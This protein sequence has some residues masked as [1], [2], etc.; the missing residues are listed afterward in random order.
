MV[1]GR[2]YLRNAPEE[3]ALSCISSPA[4]RELG[5]LP[6]MLHHTLRN[7]LWVVGMEGKPR[8]ESEQAW[9]LFRKHFMYCGNVDE[10]TW[11]EAYNRFYADTLPRD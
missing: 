11:E 1:D 7:V 3:E 10:L 9:P 8:V 6:V 2:D 4:A 5:V